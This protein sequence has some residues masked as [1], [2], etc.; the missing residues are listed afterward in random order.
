M[1]DDNIK[2]HAYLTYS[3]TAAPIS[4]WKHLADCMAAEIRELRAD[5]VWCLTH[6]AEFYDDK[7]IGTVSFFVTEARAGHDLV[8]ADRTDASLLSAVRRAREGEA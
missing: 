1:T 4:E 6:S 2:R 5:V 8:D 3:I 7:P